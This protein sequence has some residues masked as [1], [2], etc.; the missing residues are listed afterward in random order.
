VNISGQ[1][2][3]R[4]YQALR[5][6]ASNKEAN[7]TLEMAG[8]PVDLVSSRI[9]NDPTTTDTIVASSWDCGF[10]STQ[11]RLTFTERQQDGKQVL[12]FTADQPRSM[13]SEESDHSSALIDLASGQILSSAGT[14]NFLV[15]DAAPVVAPK[16]ALQEMLY[17]SI[18]ESYREIQQHMSAGE[19]EFSANG[20]QVTVKEWAENSEAG[21]GYVKVESWN[22]DFSA[23][24]STETYREYNQDGRNMLEYTKVNPG[25]PF[26]VGSKPE[27]VV[28]N[29]P[30]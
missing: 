27:T 7:A 18:R 10:S 22:G 8:Q 11:A 20:N 26:M 9:D 16:P 15:Q 1:V 2:V 21:P 25:S 28:H 29:L 14:G 17:A 5:Q 3:L 24:A 23:A 19:R 12:E 6:A 4:D 30:L 13:F